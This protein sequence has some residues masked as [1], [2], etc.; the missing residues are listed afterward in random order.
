MVKSRTRM[1][2]SGPGMGFL[3]CCGECLDYTCSEACGGWPPA[4][5]VSRR[6]SWQRALGV[7]LLHQNDGER[8]VFVGVADCGGRGEALHEDAEDVIVR[9]GFGTP[10]QKQVGGGGGG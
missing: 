7:G 8:E 9:L 6:P 10:V 1:P 2:S 5:A 3:L 4:M